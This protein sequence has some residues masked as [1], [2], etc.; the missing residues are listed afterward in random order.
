[1]NNIKT[2]PTCGALEE[3]HN[4]KTNDL[5]SVALYDQMCE[6]A[7]KALAE[8]N[9]ECIELKEKV[10]YLQKGNEELN[11]EVNERSGES[12]EFEARAEEAEEKLALAMRV[13]EDLNVSER[14]LELVERSVRPVEM[15]LAFGV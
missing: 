6:K 8:A 5:G 2:C 7:E 13:L 4:G 11:D 15:L 10:A 14:D 9:E 3:F 1:M 12:A